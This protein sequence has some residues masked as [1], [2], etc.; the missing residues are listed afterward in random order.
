MGTANLNITKGHSA[1]NDAL[2]VYV[3]GQL[4]ISGSDG[5]ADTD[6]TFI[7]ADTL[8]FAFGL[9]ADDIIQVIQR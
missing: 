3:N 4:L 7:D 8:K 1:L 6:Y 5:G 9:E 2:E